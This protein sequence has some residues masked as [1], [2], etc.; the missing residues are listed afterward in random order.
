MGREATKGGTLG[1]CSGLRCWPSS[2]GKPA[3]V[4][5]TGGPHLTLIWEG[6]QAPGCEDHWKLSDRSRFHS[7]AFAGSPL[8]TSVES[9]STMCIAQRERGLFPRD[10]S[11]ART[12]SAQIWP[13]ASSRPPLACIPRTQEAKAQCGGSCSPGALYWCPQEGQWMCPRSSNNS[14]GSGKGCKSPRPDPEMTATVR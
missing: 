4:Q 8:R 9:Q 10:G 2:Y 1:L 3:G 5:T 14:G 12:C 13:Q 11:L 7:I 6:L